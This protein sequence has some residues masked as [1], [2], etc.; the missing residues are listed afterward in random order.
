MNY[1]SAIDLSNFLAKGGDLNE[2]HHGITHFCRFMGSPYCLEFLEIIFAHYENDLEGWHKLITHRLMGKSGFATVLYRGSC[3]A[4]QFF[5]ER[6]GSIHTF[7]PDL[8]GYLRY[9]DA[10]PEKVELILQSTTFVVTEGPKK[11]QQTVTIMKHNRRED[12]VELITKPQAPISK[13]D[14]YQVEL[15]TKPQVQTS[16]LDEYQQLT[17]Y[18]PQ[19]Y[20]KLRVVLGLNKMWLDNMS[21]L[22]AMGPEHLYDPHRQ[23]LVDLCK[24]FFEAPITNASVISLRDKMDRIMNLASP[25]MYRAWKPMYDGVQL[26]AL[27]K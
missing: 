14:K 6:S 27:G 25:A 26:W 19:R 5:L 22:Y 1:N 23:Q 4:L 8:R 2:Y 20:W 3:D 18:D 21:Q 13:L 17:D 15:I 9:P 16:K 24:T 11:I 12:L 7:L 10:S